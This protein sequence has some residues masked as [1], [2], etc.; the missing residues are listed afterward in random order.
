MKRFIVGLLISG[1]LF[2]LAFRGVD[3]KAFR[4]G[5]THIDYRYLLPVIP[6]LLLIQWM[7]SYRWGLILK[8]IK[9][10]DQGTLF[11]ITC[12]GLMGVLL[13]PARAGE[14]LRPYLISQKKEID[15]RSALATVVVERVLDGL[16]IMG[17]FIWV[18]LFLPVPLWIHR[19]GYLSFAVFL[20]FFFF[21][22]LVVKRK[23][24]TLSLI[25]ILTKGFPKRFQNGI[26]TFIGSFAEGLQI[27]PDLR[28]LGLGLG[29][30]LIIW[31]L[32]GLVYYILLQS[33]HMNLPLIAGYAVLVLVVI[34]VMIPG[35]PGFVGNFHLSCVLGLSLF[36]IPK[37]EALSYSIINH[38]IVVLFTVALGVIFLPRVNIPWPSLF[39]NRK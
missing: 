24:G 35:A 3:W 19:A 8:P 34:G 7:R 38:L 1:I 21:L 36:G 4:E 27:L 2:Y 9:R 18:I 29:L 37:S 22:L 15:L 39:K 31:A 16:T 14:F 10:V 33:F 11:S 6:L 5:F 28:G 23:D 17:F 20:P 32:M 26:Q 12:V 30:S 13:F 25:R